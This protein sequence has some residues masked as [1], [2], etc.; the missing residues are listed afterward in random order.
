MMTDMTVDE[1]MIKLNNFANKY[2]LSD[3][4]T[5]VKVVFVLKQS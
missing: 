3:G 5:K 4:F 1:R 2:G